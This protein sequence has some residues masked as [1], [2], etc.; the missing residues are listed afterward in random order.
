[1]NPTTGTNFAFMRTVKPSSGLTL[2][3][4]ANLTFHPRDYAIQ[5][6]PLSLQSFVENSQGSV[7]T[8]NSTIEPSKLNSLIMRP[9]LLSSLAVVVISIFALFVVIALKLNEKFKKQNH[10]K[11]FTQDDD[12]VYYFDTPISVTHDVG[13]S[14]N[15][16]P[17]HQVTSSTGHLGVPDDSP[18]FAFDIFDC[19]QAMLQPSFREESGAFK[20]SAAESFNIQGT[21][22]SYC[23][24]TVV[25]NLTTATFPTNKGIEIHD[26]PTKIDDFDSNSSILTFSNERSSKKLRDIEKSNSQ[27]YSG[28][29]DQIIEESSSCIEYSTVLSDQ[30][31]TLETHVNKPSIDIERNDDD[32]LDSYGD[33]CSNLKNATA[34][35]ANQVN[36][37]HSE[38]EV[39]IELD[40]YS[41]CGAKHQN[42]AVSKQVLMYENDSDDS[43]ASMESYDASWA[44]EVVDK[45]VN[46][47]ATEILEDSSCLES[48]AETVDVNF[49]DERGFG[50]HYC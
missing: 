17:Q 23:A 16:Y 28:N 50:S 20:H 32:S 22:E 9:A 7:A 41:E 33:L 4:T 14:S 1:M 35:E 11:L 37:E 8:A 15:F 34:T 30:Y 43:E 44:K 38:D 26:C 5:S 46:R 49:E 48:Q 39:L 12:I 3:P 21:P 29:L 40:S 31:D 25:S 36:E 6:D 10:Q 19:R 2:A 18:N 42:G 24:E 45:R 27:A 47:I 13:F